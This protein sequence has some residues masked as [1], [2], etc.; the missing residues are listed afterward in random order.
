MISVIIPA[1]NVA[2]KIPK[3]FQCLNRQTENFGEYSVRTG[4]FL[5]NNVT[6]ISVCKII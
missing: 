4:V 2:D 1:Y 5:Y 6:F 3:M